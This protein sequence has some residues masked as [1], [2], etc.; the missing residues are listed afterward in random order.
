VSWNK[1][2]IESV[3]YFNRKKYEKLKI[4]VMNY[5]NDLLKNNRLKEQKCK[6]C[7][8]IN[9]DLISMSAFTTENCYICNKE[10]TFACSDTDKLCLDC[11][12]GNNLCKK[13]GGTID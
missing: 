6:S 12:Q 7:T 11:A 10:I 13:C 5:E 8:Y 2:N 1:K 4:K 3:D 9:N